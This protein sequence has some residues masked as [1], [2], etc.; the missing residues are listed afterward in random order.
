MLRPGELAWSGVA[1]S[2]FVDG[3]EAASSWTEGT[4][5]EG[6]AMA[7]LRRH[8]A[9][10]IGGLARDFLA[11]EAA[12]DPLRDACAR[13]GRHALCRIGDALP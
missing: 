8:W 2:T 10:S 9:E 12:V 13:C 1:E 7:A 11:G 4:D 3:L 5:D 6:E